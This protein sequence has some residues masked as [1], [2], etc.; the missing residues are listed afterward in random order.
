MTKSPFNRAN[1]AGR[2]FDK[3]KDEQ[4]KQKVERDK[5]R[6][7]LYSF[8]ISKGNTDEFLIRF[9][10]EEPILAHMHNIQTGPKKYEDYPCLGEGCEHCAAGDN[11]SYKGAWLIADFTPWERD[12]YDPKTNRKTGEKETVPFRLRIFQRGMTDTG[13]YNLKASKFGLTNYEWSMTRVGE[14]SKT[15]YN[16]EREDKVDLE[17]DIDVFIEQMPK[18]YRDFLEE[19]G[20]SQDTLMDIVEANVMQDLSIIGVVDE[21]AEEEEAPKPKKKSSFAS[22]VAKKKQEEEDEEEYD[23]DLS[24]DDLEEIDEDEED[25]PIK[26]VIKKK[27]AVKKKPVIKKRR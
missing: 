5:K 4:K 12:V 2:G 17:E 15:T 9:L 21:E 25:T 26:R 22:K 27:A 20:V 10:T 23:V 19:H 3:F 18:M 24:D 6:G 14:D 8:F 1:R 11:P 13:T 16:I 7:L